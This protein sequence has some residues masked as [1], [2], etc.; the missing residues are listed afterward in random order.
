MWNSKGEEKTG[1][2]IF[3]PDNM[4]NM[5]CETFNEVQELAWDRVEWRH[6]VESNQS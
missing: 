6:L 1:I 3:S 4:K 2:R 5:R